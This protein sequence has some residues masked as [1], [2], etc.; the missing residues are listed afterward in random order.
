MTGYELD[1][2]AIAVDDFATHPIVDACAE[3]GSLALVGA[4]DMDAR[5]SRNL[6]GRARA[7]GD[8]TRDAGVNV[9]DAHSPRDRVSRQQG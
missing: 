2:D 6:Q 3:M 9:S 8:R 4:R 5:W 1:A 7:R